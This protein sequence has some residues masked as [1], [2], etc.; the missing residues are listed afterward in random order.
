MLHRATRVTAWIAVIVA[1][2]WMGMISVLS[3]DLEALDGRLDIWMRLLQ[4]LTWVA[5]AGTM[6]I[7]WNA[8][9]MTRSPERKRLATGWTMLV[10]LSAVFLVWL[11]FSLRTMTFGLNF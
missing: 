6:L 5:V 8:W 4:L 2:G 10:A 7:I 3:S 9:I 1:A 11:A